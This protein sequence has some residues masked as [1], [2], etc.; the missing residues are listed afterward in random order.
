MSS[1]IVTHKN[2]LAAEAK[3]TIVRVDLEPYGRRAMKHEQLWTVR[4]EVGLFRVTCAPFFAEDISFGDVVAADEQGPDA[5]TVT[6]VVEKSGNRTLRIAT[7]MDGDVDGHREIIAFLDGRGLE[8]EA[9]TTGYVAANVGPH[10]D[11]GEI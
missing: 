4:V 10:V 7:A 2:P 3:N 8:W 9:L 11:L 6:G 5:Y 1:R